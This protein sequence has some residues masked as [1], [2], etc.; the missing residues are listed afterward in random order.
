MP[1]LAQ[2]CQIHDMILLSITHQLI[3]IAP[4]ANL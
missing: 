1:H 2:N 3:G 4:E